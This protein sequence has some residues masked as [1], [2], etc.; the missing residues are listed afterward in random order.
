MEQALS[1]T[2]LAE[3]DLKIRGPGELF[4]TAQHGFFGLQIATFSDFGLIKKTKLEAESL[5][6][7]EPNLAKHLLLKEKIQALLEK[8]IQPN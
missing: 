8:P 2:E 6:K 7:K 4:G 1:G 3:L 5:F